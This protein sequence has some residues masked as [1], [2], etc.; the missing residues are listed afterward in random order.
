M[1]HFMLDMAQLASIYGV[2]IIYNDNDLVVMTGKKAKLS[3]IRNYVSGKYSARLE[4]KSDVHGI[5]NVINES[6][7]VQFLGPH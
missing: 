3:E 2:K 4:L 7:H 5:F 6:E 1:K